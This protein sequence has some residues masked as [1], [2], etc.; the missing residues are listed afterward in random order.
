MILSL[1]VPKVLLTIYLVVQVYLTVQVRLILERAM[2]L[3]WLV[4]RVL[5]Y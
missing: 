2:I 4:V 3:F 1:V 5:L